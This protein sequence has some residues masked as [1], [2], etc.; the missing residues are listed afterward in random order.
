VVVITDGVDTRSRMTPAQVAAIASGIDVPVYIIAVM[1]PIDDPRNREPKAIEVTP[2]LQELARWTGG[3][4]FVASV[5]A[6]AS[7]AARQLVDEMRHQ[8]VL[9]FE[10]ASSRGWRPL[11]IR[12]REGLIVRARGGYG[13]GTE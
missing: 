10:A 6:H 7:V 12:S 2:T 4:A 13:G 3:E 8:Y 5:P 1:T 11:Q 9:A